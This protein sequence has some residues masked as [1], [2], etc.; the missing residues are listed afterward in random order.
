[1]SNRIYNKL[2]VNTNREEGS[3]KILLG[4]QHDKKEI[5]LKKDTET[6]FHVPFYTKPVSLKDTSLIIDGATGGPFP[7]ASDRIF[8]SQ[9][10]HGL[11][12]HHGNPYYN[13]ADGLWFCSWLYKDEYG[14][15][16]W[17]DRLYNPGNFTFSGARRTL[18]TS[19]PVYKANNPVFKDVPS[20]LMLEPSVLY[21]YYHVGENAAQ[22]LIETF[23]GQ[24]GNSLIMDLN[25]WGQD[26][27]NTKSVSIQ[28]KINTRESNSSLYISSKFVERPDKKTINLETEQPVEVVIDYD[29]SYNPTN[30]FTATCWMYGSNWN[31]QP[32]TQLYGN[33][34][35]KGGY[36]LSIQ[37]LSSYQFFVIP[38][39]TYGHILY[40]NETFK[41]YLDKT[42]QTTPK[43]SVK[44]SFCA[45]DLDHN[46]IVCNEDK[47]GTVYKFDNAGELLASTSLTDV[48]FKYIFPSE[49]P[50]QM[51]VGPDN[52]I[53]I[54]TESVVYTLDKNL[55]KI[56]QNVQTSTANDFA[57]FK[58]NVGDD[59]Y[60]LN[61]TQNAKD[62]KFIETTKWFISQDGNLYRELDG[63]LPELYYTFVDQADTFTIDS[64]NRLWVLHGNNNLSIFDSRLAPLTR[65]RLTTDVGFNV[66]H[67]RKN[68][69]FICVYDRGLKEYQWRCVVFYSNERYI[70]IL[71]MEGNTLKS[72]DTSS[73]FDSTLI[74]T[75]DQNYSNFKY[76][77]KGDFTGYEHRRIFQQ[78]SPYNNKSQL[79]LKASLKDGMKSQ[80]TFTQFI[81]KFPIENWPNNSWQHFTIILKNKTL[82]SYINGQKAASFSFSGRHSLS[83]ELQPLFFIGTSGGSQVGFNQE[84]RNVSQMHEGLVGDLKIYN[85]AL[86]E[87]LL[88][89]FLKG[90]ITANDIY[91]NMPV[92][93]MQYVEKIER[94]FKNKIPGIK[95]P[96]YRVKI[97]G[98]NI[99]DAKTKEIITEHLQNSLTKMHPGYTDFLE[100]QWVD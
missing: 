22:N 76:L 35:S 27:V 85:Y 2:Y 50:L 17:L 20:R 29:G 94:M 41:G 90:F 68:I 48:S 6:Y 55:N 40:V 81:D 8:K 37:S 71:D 51:L 23:S 24:T 53:I 63:E 21:K 39:T 16:F 13:T 10:N 7:A 97:R 14:N 30:E 79:V 31:N 84:V 95:S 77:N 46:V 96:L 89:I 12:T 19:G 52:T 32:T 45:I 70:Y 66:S 1:M 28:P 43:V 15:L 38:E 11:T 75:L 4:Y 60:E 34:S 86:D 44:P 47:T 57:A 88:E 74:K 98:T 82:T 78:L 58:Y 54:R 9:K 83:Y 100:I 91:W 72:L 65:P 64:D 67:D 59:F 5:R 42:I 49:T 36:G 92:P 69:S 61:I 56:D 3:E 87:S 25:N 93:L 73:L 26:N 33:Y 18:L 80:L 62:V 99:T